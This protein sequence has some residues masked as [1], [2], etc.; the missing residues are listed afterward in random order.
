MG[1]LQ[2]GGGEQERLDLEVRELRSPV[3]DLVPGREKQY[4]VERLAPAP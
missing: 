4:V 3:L 2:L 1:R